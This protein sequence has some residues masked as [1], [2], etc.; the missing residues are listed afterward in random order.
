MSADS[1]LLLEAGAASPL[2]AMLLSPGTGSSEVVAAV[3]ECLS[4]L[5]DSGLTQAQ[6]VSHAALTDISTSHHL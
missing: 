2:A 3:L 6:P 1:L 5:A 4:R